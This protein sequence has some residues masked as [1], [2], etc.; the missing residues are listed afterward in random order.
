MMHKQD[1]EGKTKHQL[2]R[3]VIKKIDEIKTEHLERGIERLQAIAK[4]TNED[5][6]CKTSY[7]ETNEE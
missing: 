3:G 6:F 2:R 4:K 5:L 7:T 1:S